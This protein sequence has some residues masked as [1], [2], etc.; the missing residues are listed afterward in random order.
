MDY[1]EN[2]EKIWQK[3]RGEGVKGLR[4]NLEEIFSDW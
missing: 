1:N 4:K 2:I 3:T